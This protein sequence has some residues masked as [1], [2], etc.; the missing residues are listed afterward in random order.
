MWRQ[1]TIDS[2]E[3][4]LKHT[5]WQSKMLSMFARSGLSV[6]WTCLGTR[7]RVGRDQPMDFVF[8]QL[9]SSSM[10]FRMVMR[11][12]DQAVPASLP[13]D[14]ERTDFKSSRALSSIG[15]SHSQ[16]E[17][18]TLSI[19]TFP[20]LDSSAQLKGLPTTATGALGCSGEGDTSRLKTGCRRTRESLLRCA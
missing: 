7:T 4:E 11:S 1:Q 10:A 6:T 18:E 13:P 3:A 20:S 15:E 14:R 16:L 2:K 5:K 17:D 9:T 12:R 8:A 19:F